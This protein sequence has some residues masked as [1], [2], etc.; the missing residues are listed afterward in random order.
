VLKLI[1]DHE[2]VTPLPAVDQSPFANHGQIINSGFLADGRSA[3]SGAREFQQADS[4]VRVAW[5]PV[6]GRLTAL[7]IEAWVYVTG[8][9]Q[10]RN[11]IEGDGSFALF[12]N[13]DDTVAGSLFSLVDGISAPA[14]NLVSSGAHSPD[15]AL[16]RVPLER[17]C[18]VVFHHDGVT[19]ARL[20]LDDQLIATRGDYRS[21]VVGVAGAGVVIGNW[22]LANQYAFSGRIDRVSVWKH[23]DAEA[24][25]QFTARP[26]SAEA[27]D[28]WDEIWECLMAH[29]N[30]DSAIRLRALS[31]DWEQ[32]LREL[33]RAAHAA[34]PADRAEFLRLV[35]A[36][37]QHW[38]ENT[39]DS[40]AAAGT[41]A[42]M[43][44]WI[45]TQIGTG[46]TRQIE[47]SANLLIGLFGG[48]A[49]CFDA[50]RLG[51]VDPEFPRFVENALSQAST[52]AGA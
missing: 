40:M 15:G 3:G 5:R 38:H 23:D 16:H 12:V 4:A 20:F 41:I 42:D 2:F 1:L 43:Q 29:V 10:R 45:T 36:Y 44:H 21:G 26:I 9:G 32:L 35:E 28:H 30:P 39:I 8:N 33:F 48:G 14:W 24:M 31:R 22:T 17:W 49:R 52:G 47:D 34:S 18:K 50:K 7:A 6:W 19:R 46:W 11:I 27:R 51:T 37:Q 25:R 13:P